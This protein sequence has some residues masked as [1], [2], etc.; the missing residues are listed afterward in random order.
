MLT[1]FDLEMFS[2]FMISAHTAI[3][4]HG[5]EDQFKKLD[6][7]TETVESGLIVLQD[8]LLL[9][10]NHPAYQ[11]LY[12]SHDLELEDNILYPFYFAA[13]YGCEKIFTLFY[14]HEDTH[15]SA[16]KM[17]SDYS[18]KIIM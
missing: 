13:K 1:S 5:N 12:S 14:F 11:Y 9:I 4:H 18:R 15:E 3:T 8:A 7:A 17:L 16:R 6:I 10:I 2:C